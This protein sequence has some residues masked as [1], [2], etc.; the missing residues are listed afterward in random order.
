[1][2]EAREL[3][4]ATNAAATLK[5]GLLAITDDGEA[6]RDTIEGSTN[7]HEAIR[8]T[9]LS[10]E[11]DEVLA[12]SLEIR[13]GLNTDRLRRFKSRIEAKKAL[14]EQAMT[15]GEITSREYD[16][17]TISMT[18]RPRKVVITDEASIPSDYFNQPAPKL[19]K[20]KL[21]NALKAGATITGA[22]LDNGHSSLTIRRK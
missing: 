7:L 14:I 6:I 10:I 11:D 1:M 15:I 20:D 16:I 4:I 17:A 5:A 21:K 9:V 13:I 19:D 18:A 2:T 8:A 22:T 3:E 12:A